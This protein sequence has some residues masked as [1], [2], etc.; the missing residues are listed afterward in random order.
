MRN[1]V[2]WCQTNNLQ[3]NT[4]K[5]KELVMDFRRDRPRPRPV[6]LGAEEV[7][8]VETYK[9]LGLWLD[10]KLDW[11]SNTKQ[12]YKK[13]QSRLYFLRRLRY[14]SICRKLLQMLYQSVVTSVV[15]YAV[16]CWAGSTSK[17]DLSR[18]EKLVRRA[19]SVVGMKLDPLL[20]VAERRTLNKL[21]GILDNTNHPLHT[22]ISSQRSRLTGCSFQRAGQTD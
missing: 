2:V 9:Y 12:Q 21:Q 5:T 1:F 16:V 22:V 8:V 17:A 13:A 10:N 15:S 6:L 19:G 14:L 7:E 20:T 4:S 18:L 11:T 3:L